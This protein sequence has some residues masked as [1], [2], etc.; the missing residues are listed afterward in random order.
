M[1]KSV[2]KIN[3]LD[4]KGIRQLVTVADELAK[5]KTAKFANKGV[6]PRNARVMIVGIPNVGNL[7]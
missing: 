5:V 1:G 3:S 6:K 7:L 2:V 4:G